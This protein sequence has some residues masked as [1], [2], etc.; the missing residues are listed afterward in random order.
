MFGLNKI[1]SWKIID[2]NMWVYYIS[3]ELWLCEGKE[4]LLKGCTLLQK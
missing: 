1:K 2:D 4:K 3:Y